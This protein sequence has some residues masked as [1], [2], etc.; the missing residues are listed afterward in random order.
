MSATNI[1]I[2]TC[3]AAKSTSSFS[4]SENV[5]ELNLIGAMLANNV[6]SAFRPWSPNN[7][8]K[9]MPIKPPRRNRSAN[10]VVNNPGFL[11]TGVNFRPDAISMT[12][13]TSLEIIVKVSITSVG[14]VAPIALTTRAHNGGDTNNFFKSLDVLS[15][16]H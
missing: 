1:A 14:G 4:S 13:L 2:D 15:P 6:I 8:T 12:G 7:L 10:D 5:I 3:D 9:V 16:L 11:I